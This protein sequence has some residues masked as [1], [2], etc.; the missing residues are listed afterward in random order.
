VISS[1]E[2]N[3]QWQSSRPGSPS[4]LREDD[5]AK[6]VECVVRG[7]GIKFIGNQHDRPPLV[8][9]PS[10]SCRSYWTPDYLTIGLQRRNLFLSLTSARPQRRLI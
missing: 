5:A 2:F 4:F 8:I 6:L 1:Q 9:S 7:V 10:S 3:R